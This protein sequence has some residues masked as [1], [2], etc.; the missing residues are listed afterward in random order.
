MRA[1]NAGP[2]TVNEA[3]RAA[4]ALQQGGDWPA[5]EQAWRDLLARFGSQPDAEHMLGLTLH[6][7]GRSEEA[8]PWFERA[9]RQRGGA[10]LW[11][12]HAAALLALGRAR[13]AA[14]L[15]RRA[16]KADAKH[17]GAWLNL[18][19]ADEIEG[20]FGEAA[21]ALSNALQAAPG[22]L[23]ARRALA[24]CQ[25]AMK[26]AD[27][28][29]LALS[30]V[31]VGRDAAIDLVRAEALIMRG[32]LDAASTLL[33][34]LVA[35]DALRTQALNLQAEIALAR[36]HSNAALATLKRVIDID[37][38]NRHAIIKTALLQIARGEAESGLAAMRDWLDGHP[39]DNATA[40]S[41]LV[42]CNYSERFDPPAMLAEHRRVQ[43]PTLMAPE[44]PS[45]Y[46]ANTSGQLRI[47]WVSTAF[48][49]GPMEIFFAD[50]VRAFAKVSPDVQHVLYA[51]GGEST[52]AP[53]SAAWAQNTRDLS[54]LGTAEI[55][56]AIRADGVDVL[57]DLVGRAAGNRIA[58]FAARAAP[59]Q[60]G[61]LDVFYP[62][63]L[64]TMDFLVTDPWLSPH[65]ADA[66]FSEKL[67]RLPHG[68][69]AYNAPPVAEPNIEAARLK[70]FISLNR[71]SKCGDA[72]IDV[73]ASI[74]RELPD[75]T[76][77]LKAQGR[78]DDLV[79]HF[80]EKFRA[81]RV[82]PSRI[83]IEGGGPYAE[84]MAAYNRGAIALDPFP[85]S[86]CSTSCDALWMGLPVITLPHA[87]IASRQTAA[88][89]EL[90]G[91]PEWIARD[92]DDYLAKAVSLAHDEAGRIQWRRTARDILRPA[93]CDS[94][95]CARELV[96]ALRTAAGR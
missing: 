38:G 85:F 58:L 51:I 4:L 96:D 26:H 44:W 73:W 88:W 2:T 53:P 93:I 64:D 74:L 7:L 11:S 71:F 14:S 9:G 46:R 27:A 65:G 25:L 22:N 61:W 78:D 72:V 41:Y 75:W 45:G 13:E 20:K 86:G 55:L 29:L 52:T 67:I 42:A 56:E 47:G 91:R 66:D 81:R 62:S 12:N 21:S 30:S 59:M 1:M 35:D 39:D 23:A 68:R 43:P 6:A 31:A 48:S 57:V 33:E 89:L 49:V 24:R 15:A 36:G 18:G 84:A 76:L 34:N 70:Q 3:L 8:L 94:E 87:T 16:V 32:D 80:L 60:V 37:A 50:V 19:L 77:L 90:A 28:A 82:D 54:R 63:G 40:G 95:R 17:A 5:A 69:L 79:S 92:A 83:T 10:M